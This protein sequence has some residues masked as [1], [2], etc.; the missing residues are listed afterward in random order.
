MKI[1]LPLNNDC[2]REALAVQKEA[3]SNNF[4]SS[5][6]ALAGSVVLFHFEAIKEIQ[7]ECPLVLCYSKEC[8][9]GM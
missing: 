3:L 4:I 6:I 2:L 5:F 9:T 8:G 1:E 7:D